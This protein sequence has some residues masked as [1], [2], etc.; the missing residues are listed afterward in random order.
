METSANNNG[1][2]KSSKYDLLF[3]LYKKTLM[4]A[5]KLIRGKCTQGK[6]EDASSLSNSQQLH[7]SKS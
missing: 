4:E 7:T 1:T 6:D 5:Q 2:L 3:F